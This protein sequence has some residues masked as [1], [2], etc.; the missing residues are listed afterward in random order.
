MSD[1][2]AL[3]AVAVQFWVNGMIFSSFLPRLPELRASVGLGL[4][5]LGWALTAGAIG[6]FV[7]SALC[8]PVVARHGPAR[9]T[10]VGG[11]GM[12]VALPFVGLAPTAVAFA[13]LLMLLHLFDT[14]ADVGMNIIGS[15]VSARRRAPVISRL[16]GLWSVGTLCGGVVATVAAGAVSLRIQLGLVAVVLAGALAFVGPRLLAHDRAHPPEA[17]RPGAPGDSDRDAGSGV[18][19]GVGETSDGPMVGRSS[20]SNRAMWWRLRLAALATAAVAVEITPSDWASVALSDDLGVD[21]TRAAA[22][23]VAVTVGMVAGRFAGDWLTTTVGGARLLRASVAT[24]LAGIALVAAGIGFASA[25]IGLAMAGLGASV[26]FP[27][28]YDE[29]AQAPG[30]PGANLGALTAGIRVGALTIPVSVGVLSGTTLT[31][32]AAMAAV[33]I[34]ATVVLLTLGASTQSAP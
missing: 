11:V 22:G 27:R 1:R 19:V 21:E 26:L 23:F 30:R 14:I 25:V 7:G 29:A 16:H 12:V 6:G 4:T 10:I 5:G 32:G 18:G 28:L 3:Q 9:T 8:G 33:M 17:E 31:V 34:P 13:G 2:A 24:S 20:S 15:D